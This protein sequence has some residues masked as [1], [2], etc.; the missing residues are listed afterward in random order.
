MEQ[1]TNIKTPEF[2][3]LQFQI[4]GLGSRATALITDMIILLIVNTLIIVSLVLAT[5]TD[6]YLS[7][8]NI[9]SGL[10]FAAIIILFFIINFG[11]Y[12]VFEFFWGGKTI[13]KR[14]IGIRV[15]QDNGHPITLLSSIIRNLLRLID[16]LPIAYFIGMLFVFFHG[17]HKRLGD[18]AAGTLVVHEGRI[19]RKKKNNVIEKIIQARRLSREDLTLDKQQLNQFTQHDW[20][21]LNTFCERY[22]VLPLHEKRQLTHQ[23]ATIL[24]PKIEW[25]TEKLSVVEIE[26]T[27]FVLYL[28]LRDE[29]Q[30]E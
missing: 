5:E 8:V 9:D 2:V 17:Q 27:L 21:L 13:G 3:S 6:L 20:R 11:Y 10:L 1:Q 23:V 15:I 30:F 25:S 29:W 4:A 12:I 22:D 14:L 28:H 26:N 7:L 19:A 24:F 16:S 18:L